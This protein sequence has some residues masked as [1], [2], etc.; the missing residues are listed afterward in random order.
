MAQSKIQSEQGKSLPAYIK[1]QRIFFAVCIALG[2]LTHFVYVTFDPTGS[3]G[4]VSI[5][6]NAAAN[7]ATNQLHLAFGVA[8]SFLLPIGYLGMALLALRRTP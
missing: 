3:L 2:P 7:A 1:V 4:R 6:A 5:A 8:A